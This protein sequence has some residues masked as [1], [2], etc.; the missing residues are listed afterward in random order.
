MKTRIDIHNRQID[1]IQAKSEDL[2]RILTAT[3]VPDAMPCFSCRFCDY[4]VQL[5]VIG[6]KQ[7]IRF[8]ASMLNHAAE[9]RLS[10]IANFI[11]KIAVNNCSRGGG[12]SWRAGQTSL[13]TRNEVHLLDA[14][15]RFG[16]PIGE[17]REV[18]WIF[19]SDSLRGR[20]ANARPIPA[21]VAKA[22][23][24][25][26]AAGRPYVRHHHPAITFAIAAVCRPI[27]GRLQKMR[28]NS[29]FAQ[30]APTRY[31]LDVFVRFESNRTT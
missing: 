8:H 29:Q 23:A 22:A 18:R 16:K 20:V 2:E 1:V 24:L 3:P 10:I 6:N 28:S 5:I 9:V 31:S 11:A 17:W 12:V 15:I 21:I 30:R 13:T 26:N 14:Q 7:D 4:G 27:H 19:R 25:K